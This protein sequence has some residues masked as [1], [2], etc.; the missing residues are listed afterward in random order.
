MERQLQHFTKL[1]SNTHPNYKLQADY[2]LY[3]MEHFYFKIIKIEKNKLKRKWIESDYIIKAKQRELKGGIK[4][5]NIKIPE[6]KEIGYEFKNE[7]NE[8]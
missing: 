1:R 2:E 3:G 5:Y 8:K 4:I 7:Q 6:R